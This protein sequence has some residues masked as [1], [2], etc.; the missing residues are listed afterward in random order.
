MHYVNLIAK[1]RAQ[2]VSAKRV[3]R[4]GSVGVLAAVV[5]WGVSVLLMATHLRAIDRQ[6]QKLELQAL[7]LKPEIDR[8]KKA[9]Q[10]QRERFDQ[11]RFYLQARKS[12]DRWLHSLMEIQRRLPDDAWITNLETRTEGGVRELLI[13]GRALTEDSVSMYFTELATVRE[14]S[15]GGAPP[16]LNFI[17]LSRAGDLEVR[18][19][20]ITARLSGPT[21]TEATPGKT[22]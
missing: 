1:R 8:L 16:Q 18:E 13:E 6:A 4:A 15:E 2:Q 14:L 7:P 19:F 11:A 20:Q 10:T 12:Q 22:S 21:K 9:Q 3:V 5:L 17:R